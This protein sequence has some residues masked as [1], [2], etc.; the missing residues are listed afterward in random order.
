[1]IELDK[2]SFSIYDNEVNEIS[3]FNINQE[4]VLLDDPLSEIRKK[5]AL[6]W[7]IITKCIIQNELVIVDRTT[8]ITK[9]GFPL[10]YQID[11]LGYPM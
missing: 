6:Q 9:S 4:L 2:I 8:W 3:Q 1:L 11:A 7:N 5:T 10:Q